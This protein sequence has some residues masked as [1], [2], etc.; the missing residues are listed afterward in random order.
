MTIRGFI[1]A[2]MAIGVTA[3]VTAV[4][5]QQVRDSPYRGECINEAR[6][7]PG[8]SSQAQIVAAAERCIARKEQEATG[9]KQKQ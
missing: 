3:A 5:A 8:M 4:H 9:K 2:A 7:T 6:A 1:T